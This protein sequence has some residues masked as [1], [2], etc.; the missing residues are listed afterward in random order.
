MKTN[1]HKNCL[2][3]YLKGRTLWCA[4]QLAEMIPKDYSEIHTEIMRLAIQFLIEE[5]LISIKLV[6]TKCLIKF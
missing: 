4:A 6:A 1:F 2:K 5:K 3:G